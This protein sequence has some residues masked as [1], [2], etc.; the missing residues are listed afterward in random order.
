MALKYKLVVAN[1]KYTSQGEEKTR[2]LNIG[3]IMTTKKGGLVMKLDAVPTH[4]IDQQGESTPWDGWIKMFAADDRQEAS[5]QPSQQAR[6]EDR[7]GM[8]FDNIP[9]IDPYKFTSLLV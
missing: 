9:F 4:V 8:E 3:A 2:W 1:G 7:G 6:T 5:R